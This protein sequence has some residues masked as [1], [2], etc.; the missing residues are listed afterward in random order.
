MDR[1]T[2]LYEGGLGSTVNMVSYAYTGSYN[3]NRAYAVNGL[4][5]YTSAGAA[6]FSYDANGNLT[7][8][9]EYNLA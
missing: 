1:M 3:V 6:S 7:K 5:Q 9:T 2:V 8:V 4:N